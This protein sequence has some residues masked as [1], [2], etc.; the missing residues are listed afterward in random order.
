MD[1]ALKT[2]SSLPADKATMRDEFAK[3][4]LTGIIACVRDHNGATTVETRAAKAYEYADAMMAAR[5]AR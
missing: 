4:A 2:P 3:A 5:M 1:G